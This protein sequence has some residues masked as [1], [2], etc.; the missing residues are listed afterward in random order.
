MNLD[1]AWLLYAAG[2]VMDGAKL[3]VDIYEINPPLAIYFDFPPVGIARLFGWPEIPVFY[4]YVLALVGLSLLL[5]RNLINLIFENF[6]PEVRASAFLTLFFS[7]PSCPWVNLA[8]E[9]T[10]SLF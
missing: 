9:N 3:Y 10:W 6:G 7:L 8:S 5:S 1:V 2:R 4:G